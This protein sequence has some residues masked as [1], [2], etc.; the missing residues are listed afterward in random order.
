MWVR[1]APDPNFFFIFLLHF[2]KSLEFKYFEGKNPR[3]SC[4][5]NSYGTNSTLSYGTIS[6]GQNSY[7]TNSTQNYGTISY[8][9]NSCVQ[10][11]YD[12]KFH[13]QNY[14]GKNSFSQIEGESTM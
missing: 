12:T 5:I 4:G 11:E 6:C 8:L 9:Q 13:G 3:N 14:F 7:G 2:H 10:K 1:A